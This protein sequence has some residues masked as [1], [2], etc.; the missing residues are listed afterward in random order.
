MKRKTLYLLLFAYLLFTN[1]FL[2]AAPCD[3]T[4]PSIYVTNYTPGPNNTCIITFDFS[5]LVDANGGNKYVGFHLWPA[6]GY[7]N[8]NFETANG[9]STANVTSNGTQPPLATLLVDNFAATPT[10]Y[11]TYAVESPNQ[12]NVNYQTG[13][14]L[15]LGGN[16]VIGGVTYRLYTF[17]NMQITYPG[18]CTG[19]INLIGESWSA[20]SAGSTPRAGCQT[21]GIDIT[22]NTPT[23]SSV[24]VCDPVYN[25]PN[26]SNR[27][28]I[29]FT[30]PS[31]TTVTYTYAIYRDTNGD[32]LYTEGIDLLVSGPATPPALAPNGSYSTG[33]ITINNST[34][35]EKYA[36]LFVVVSNIVSGTTTQE[37]SII[38]RISNNCQALPVNFGAIRAINK[39]DQLIIDWQALT[40]ENVKEYVV[41][42]SKDGANWKDI[43]KISSKAANGSSTD[44]LLYQLVIGMPLSLG[45]ISI[46]LLL[47]L[48]AFKNRKL[49]ISLMAII[50]ILLITN[51]CTKQSK[52]ETSVSKQDTIYIRIAQFDNEGSAPT[53]SKIVKVVKE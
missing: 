28:V 7:P 3:V 29:T 32:H 30:N 52:E 35:Q 23:V 49:R 12:Y 45:A 27:V 5:I 31:N 42:A 2:H 33:F 43:G 36:D 37:N 39:N 6:S 34:L 20:Q 25:D 17:K 8:P 46:A 48:P 4:A 51:A 44:T 1:N 14:T 16:T 41:Q 13:A 10:L 11:T 15:V 26:Q 50:T 18:P 38:S 40:E 9:T 53:Y 22:L 24:F 21:A 19:S 47:L